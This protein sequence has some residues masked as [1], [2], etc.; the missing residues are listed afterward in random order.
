MKN[1]VSCFAVMW[2]TAMFAAPLTAQTGRVD[3]LAVRLASEFRKPGRE[4]ASDLQQ[5]LSQDR[6][7][8]STTELNALTDSL[9]HIVNSRNTVSIELRRAII[10]AIGLAGGERTSV[11]F[12]GA[13][14]ALMRIVE[15]DSDVV[16][17]AVAALRGL[18]NK[19]EAVRY[20][21]IVAQSQ[22]TGASTAV[23]IL[24]SDPQLNGLGKAELR[25]LWLRRAVTQKL[26]L[27]GITTYAEI[28]R[29]NPILQR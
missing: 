6:G 29:W 8:R 24:Y 2:V 27:E 13:A 22:S 18:A 28:E 3:S 26:A 11:P 12:A 4:G 1:P 15:Y 21:S 25:Q 5:V 23:M 7:R 10:S 19:Q 17:G 16:G 20:L 9:V 14:T